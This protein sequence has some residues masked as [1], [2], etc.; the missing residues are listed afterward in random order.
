MDKGAKLLK[1]KKGL[2]S[3][4]GAQSALEED[5]HG[6]ED[7]KGL[8]PIE[9]RESASLNGNSYKDLDAMLAE[10]ELPNWSKLRLS[11]PTLQA[12]Q[13][14]GFDTPTA[15]QSLA[16]P[17]IIQGHDLIGKASTGSG[18]TLAFGIPILEHILSLP[19]QKSRLPVALIIAPTRELAKQIVTHLEDIAKFSLGEM[20]VVNVIGGLAI[21]KQLRILQKRPS[22]VVGTPGR[23]WEVLSHPEL[24]RLQL[25][26]LLK[27]IQF[28]VLD[29]AD[30]LLQEGHFKEIEN[31][32]ECVNGG[33]SK[34]TL[35][36]SATFQKQLQQK[37]KGRK[38]FDGN[39]LTQD[40]ALG[41]IPS[42]TFL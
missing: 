8:I 29:E 23:L 36:F 28:L 32:L 2:K 40:D 5:R 30:R 6:L 38:T 37:L 26:A 21:Q 39:L 14:L 25:D 4:K 17:R 42:R 3:R 12:L 9:V 31:I 41:Q 13:S 35:V 22:V 24:K 1:R 33:E 7:G 15:I 18:K 27:N 10:I 16:I 20:T 34:Q 11:Q 19:N